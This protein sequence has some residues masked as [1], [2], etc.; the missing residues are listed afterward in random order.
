[1]VGRVPC[2]NGEWDQ[3]VGR[4]IRRDEEMKS[5]STPKNVRPSFWRP[6]TKRFT[7]DVTSSPVSDASCPFFLRVFVFAGLQFFFLTWH[8]RLELCAQTQTTQTPPNANRSKQEEGSVAWVWLTDAGRKQRSACCRC[9]PRSARSH[10]KMH[11]NASKS[12]PRKCG[13]P[14]GRLVRGW[15]DGSICRPADVVA[16]T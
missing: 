9:S 1:M 8:A 12:W 14:S 4:R 6:A 2:N 16:G 10:S 13:M 15:T 7:E 3:K 5:G 11:Q